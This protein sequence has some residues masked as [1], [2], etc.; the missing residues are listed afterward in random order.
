MS[1]II[2][3]RDKFVWKFDAGTDDSFLGL[4]SIADEAGVGKVIEVAFDQ[5]MALKDGK[6]IWKEVD[7]RADEVE[8]QVLII[9]ANEVACLRKYL[10]SNLPKTTFWQKITRNAVQPNSL[11]QLLQ[12]MMPHLSETETN[13]FV[14]VW[15]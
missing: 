1:A 10:E 12:A 14:F 5:G 8:G 4:D 15:G 7:P 3:C 11:I 6:T 9:E 13:H 2:T